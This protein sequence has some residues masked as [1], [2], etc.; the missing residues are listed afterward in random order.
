MT[1]LTPHTMRAQ[2]ARGAVI[3]AV[4]LNVP[5][6]AWG[7]YASKSSLIVGVIAAAVLGA[8]LGGLAA[9]MLAPNRWDR[10]W[11]AHRR[12][13]RGTGQVLPPPDDLAH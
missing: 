9:W 1:S 4:V 11:S 12:R 10:W 7:W 5:T 6:L 2:V 8:F 13:P 3:G